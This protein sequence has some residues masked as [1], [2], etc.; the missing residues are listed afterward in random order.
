M[1]DAVNESRHKEANVGTRESESVSL[2][3]SQEPPRRRMAIIGLSGSC[4]DVIAQE[5][6]DVG[7]DFYLTKLFQ[8]SAVRQIF[9]TLKCR[10]EIDDMETSE[11]KLDLGPT[12]MNFIL[13]D[14]SFTSR[15]PDP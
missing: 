2:R 12:D 7:M 4:D 1:K 5:A 6:L 15:I 9:D 14:N 10:G 3:G 8:Y 13:M 11:V